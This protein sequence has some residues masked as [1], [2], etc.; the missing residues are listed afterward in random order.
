M[1]SSLTPTLESADLCSKLRYVSGARL[2]LDRSWILNKMGVN[3]KIR[4]AADQSRNWR[5]RRRDVDIAY[6]PRALISVEENVD[7]YIYLQFWSTTISSAISATEFLLLR[8]FASDFYLTLGLFL[9][10]PIVFSFLP[11]YGPVAAGIGV[12]IPSIVEHYKNVFEKLG[13]RFLLKW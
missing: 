11:L 8:P 4:G 7:L 10:V 9:Y 5:T 13:P 12:Y 3:C 1:V 6:W 2:R